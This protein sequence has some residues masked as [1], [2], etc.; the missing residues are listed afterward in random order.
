[1]TRIPIPSF[2]HKIMKSKKLD[3]V[4]V[5]KQFEDL[6]APRLRLSLT[7]RAVYW[8]LLRY[9]RLEGRARL[10]FSLLWLAGHLHI[11]DKTARW[12]VRRLIEKKVL[13]LIKRD[14]LGHVVEVRLPGK[15]A[16]RTLLKRP[17]A[18]RQSCPAGRGSTKWISCGCASCASPSTRA[19]AASAFIA[20]A[21]PPS[22][23]TAWTTWCRR[24]GPGA[25][26]TATWF[27]AA[28]IA[29]RARGTV[30]PEIFCAG[31][32]AKGA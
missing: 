29:I 21:R 25:I 8:H 14:N 3:V 27:P 15:F 20:C 7:E 1:M 12:A 32:C 28:W 9:S 10:R 4:E 18:A 26:R 16:R 5:C 17:R 6:L 13:R 22:G 11:S 2:G 31:S 19:K 24:R 30:R 23:H